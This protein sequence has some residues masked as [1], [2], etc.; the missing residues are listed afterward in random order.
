VALALCIYELT[1]TFYKI[2][3]G[4]IRC[5]NFY[6]LHGHINFSNYQ[7]NG[8]NSEE[9]A[10]DTSRLK[11][12]IKKQL[13]ENNEQDDYYLLVRKFINYFGSIG[14]FDDLLTTIMFQ[15]LLKCENNKVV[16]SFLPFRAIHLL[17]AVYRK[18]F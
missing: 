15:P 1:E 18:T 4:D 3:G 2:L 6:S 13:S 8:N 14:G 17:L 12:R 10:D 7:I 11:S 16:K 5:N 9:Y